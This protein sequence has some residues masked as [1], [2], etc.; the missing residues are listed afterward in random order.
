MV[1][2]EDIE[3]V[4]LE[5]VGFHLKNFDMAIIFKDFTRSVHR[6]DQVP[7]VNL[8]NIK[9]WLATLDI[10]YYEGKSNLNWKPLLKQIKD[11]PDEWLEAGGWEF[12]NNEIDD[13]DE[14]E[15]GED[16]ESESDFAP[17]DD[18]D[19][20]SESEEESDS[21]SVVESDDDDDD[22]GSTLNPKH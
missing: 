13:E 22:A 14:G 3:V 6:I 1:S 9:Q 8:D 17:S 2:A 18:S 12:L 19:E 5:R 20:E 4:N 11:F 10:K 21:G 15:G 7:V 16:A